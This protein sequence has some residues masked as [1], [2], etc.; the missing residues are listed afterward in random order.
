MHPPG[1]PKA[2]QPMLSV[3]E[4]RRGPKL[5]TAG[6]HFTTLTLINLQSPLD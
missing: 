1:V 5:T 4:Q 2:S 3:H 6:T